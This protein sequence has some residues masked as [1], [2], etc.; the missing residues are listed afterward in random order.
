L[1]GGSSFDGSALDEALHDNNQSAVPDQVAF[2]CD[3]PEWHGTLAGRD[4]VLV[5]ELLQGEP[6]KDVAAHLGVSPGRVSQ[7]R[8]ALRD[9]WRRFTGDAVGHPQRQR[10]GY[11]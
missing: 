4:R 8:R 1:P 7:K 10:P 6:A 2:R 5:N 3:F 9:D 11:A